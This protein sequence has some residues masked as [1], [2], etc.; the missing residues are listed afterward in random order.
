M[1]EIVKDYMKTEVISV[2]KGATLRQITKIMT[3]KNVGSVIITEKGKPIG[4]VTERDVVRA[5]GKDHKLDDKVDDI[6]TASL[7]TVRE[8]SPITGALSLMR[9]YNIRHLPV[10]N[11]DGKLTGIISIRDVAR[12]LDDMFES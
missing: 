4:I 2:E 10:V 5:I 8:D 12:A 1:E 7:I 11:Q 9:T 3:E 6:M